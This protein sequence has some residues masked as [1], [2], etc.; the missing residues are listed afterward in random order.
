MAKTREQI[1]REYSKLNTKLE[2][3]SWISIHHENKGKRIKAKMQAADLLIKV[4]AIRNAA[5]QMN[6]IAPAVGLR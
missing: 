6:I 2:R 3:I 1:I 4:K 5:H